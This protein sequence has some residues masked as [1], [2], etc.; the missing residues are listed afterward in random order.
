MTGHLSQRYL[1]SAYPS[2]EEVSHHH[3]SPY[4]VSYEMV[5]S[6]VHCWV[7]SA[8]TVLSVCIASVM[9]HHDRVTLLLVG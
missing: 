7:N 4:L 2:E 9:V 3:T 1:Y 6:P 8:G 5:V